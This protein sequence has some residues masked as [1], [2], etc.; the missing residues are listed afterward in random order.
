MYY[1]LWFG[2]FLVRSPLLKESFLLSF[3]MGTKMFQF[4][5]FP[6]IHYF[7]YVQIYSLFL[8]YEFPHSDIHGY[9]GYLLLP[10]AFRSLSRPSSALGAQASSLCSLQL[11]LLA[12]SKLRIALSNFSK[13]FLD[14]PTYYL[15][16]FSSFSSHYSF[17]LCHTFSLILFFDFSVSLLTISFNV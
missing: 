14:I 3:P 4:P 7:T 9:I 2:L 16:N 1:Y 10:V 8:L 12:S 11:N 13:N 5:T 6:S 17:I 15:K